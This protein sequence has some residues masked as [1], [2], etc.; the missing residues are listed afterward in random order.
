M[1]SGISKILSRALGVTLCAVCALTCQ[2]RK[3]PVQAAPEGFP[4]PTGPVR[5][6]GV[7]VPGIPWQPKVGPAQPLRVVFKSPVQRA[8]GTVAIVV[9]F[10]QPMVRLGR[11]VSKSE[12][13]SRYPLVIQPPVQAVY[14]WVAGDTLKVALTEPLL[15]AHRYRVT[16]PG[17][18]KS[19]AGSRLGKP[20]S[21]Q[22]ETPR[23]RLT[24]VERVL[25]TKVHHDRLHPSD[26]LLMTFNTQ[27]TLAEVQRS[28]ALTVNG[29]P[30][31][32]TLSR[33]KKHPKNQYLAVLAPVR[34]PPLSAA[35]SI[36]QRRG[37]RTIEGPLVADEES[38]HDF[39]V[40]GPLKPERVTCDRQA[41][42][43][44][45]KC[46]PMANGY[47][48]GLVLKL[49]EHVTQE[50]LLRHLQ[51][52][53][54]PRDLKKRLQPHYE[55][56]WIKGKQR[57]SCARGWQLQ[58]D[59][60]PR[61]AYR[62]RLTAGLRD[63][64]GQ[65]LAKTEAFRFSTRDFPPGVF[66]PSATTGFRELW[67][68]Y[69]F[70]A[71]NVK[72]VEAD[73]YTFRDA[74]L[75]RFLTCQRSS[76]DWPKHCLAKRT[77]RRV[78]VKMRGP[79]NKVLAGT[80]RLPAGL[81][82]VRFGSPQVVDYKGK[83]IL[84]HRTMTKT[85]LGLQTRLTAYGLT[86]WVTS[87]KTAKPVAGT[88]VSIFNLAGQRLWQG[89]TDPRGVAELP[90]SALGAKDGRRPPSLV[91]QA[92]T[93]ADLAYA[94]MD[95]QRSSGCDWTGYHYRYRYRSDSLDES[96]IAQCSSLRGDKP[97]LAGHVSTERGIYRPGHTVHLHGAVRRYAAWRGTPATGLTV[98]LRV[99]NSSKVEVG[100]RKVKLRDH[101]VFLARIALPS[102]GRLGYY[103]AELWAEGEKLASRSFKVAEYRPPRFVT[104]VRVRPKPVFSDG[105]L[106]VAV[107]GRYLFGGAMGGAAYNLNITRSVYSFTVPDRYEY[108]VGAYGHLV[109]LPGKTWHRSSSAL[110]NQGH[111]QTRLD[112]RAAGG[113]PLPWPCSHR[114]EAEVRSAA[115]RT[116]AG[117][118]WVRQHPGER[119]AA[120]RTLDSKGDAV[121]RH[122]LVVTPKGKARGGSTVTV[123]IYATKQGRYSWQIV[124]EWTRVLL[125]RKLK[126]PERGS[127][128]AVDWPKKYPR[129]NAVLW[130]SVTDAKGREARTAEIVY[131]PT[132]HSKAQE[133]ARR[134]Q[135]KIERE[136]TVK[137]DKDPEKERYLPGETAVITITRQGIKGDVVLFVERERIFRTIPLIFDA[138][139]KAQV[140]LKVLERYARSITLRAVTVRAGKELRGEKGALLSAGARLLVS[141]KPYELNVKLETDRKVYR[142]GK[143]VSVT[144]AVTDGLKRPRQSRVVLMAVDE[145][146]LNL[147]GYWLPDPY[148]DLAYT[149]PNGV[150]ADDIRHH[151]A[152]LGIDVIHYHHAVKPGEH[153][154]G[155][156]GGFGRGGGGGGG[157]ASGLGALMGSSVGK[158]KPRRKFLTTAWH[159]TVMTDEKGRA[160]TSFTLPDNTT[161]YRIMA[162]AV[163]RKRSAGT[164]H[165]RFEVDLP[166]LSL[167]ALPRL[168]RAGDR[169]AAGIVIYNQQTTGTA[170]VT[171]RVTGAVRLT[172]PATKHVKLVKGLGANVRFDLEALKQGTAKFTFTVRVGAQVD[173]I[174]QTLEVWRPTLMEASSV[175]GQTKGAVQ[176]GI[177]KMAG[178]RSDVG[179]L[180]VSLASTALTG[181]EDGM[182]QLIDYPYGCLEQ[183]ASRL[184]AMIAATALGDRF[185]IKLP[186]SPRLWIST[187]I[188]QVL[189]MQR[190]DGGFGYWPSSRHSWPWATAYALIVLHRAKLAKG[191]TGVTVP[192]DAVTNAKRY[193]WRY[194]RN[195]N[196]PRITGIT[197]SYFSFIVYALQF[198]GRDTT[199][200]AVK[201]AKHRL[202]QPLF[203]RSLLLATLAASPRRGGRTK[204]SNQ[205]DKLIDELADELGNSLR[206][207]GTTAH[208]EENLGWG[209]QVMMHSNDRTTAMV[210][211]ALINARPRHVM[212][213]RLVRWFLQGRKQARFRNTQE[214]AWAV[215]AL[216]DYARILEKVVPD[217]EAGV[218]IGRTRVLKAV[219]KGRSVKPQ[220]R[221]L[222]MRDIM[223]VAGRAARSLLIAKR[224]KGTL[225]YV[226][227]L[228]YARLQLP[229]KPRDRGFEVRKAVQ[230]LSNAGLPL[231]QQRPP[232]LGDTVLVTLSIKTTEARRYLVVDDPMPAGMEAID[233]SLATATRSV[234]ASLWQFRSTWYDHRELRDDRVLFFRDLVQPSTLTFRYL[235]RV[236]TP[237]RYVSP[238]TKA[239][240]MYNPEIF[241][242][243]ATRTVTYKKR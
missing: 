108:R 5:M 183:K 27:V 107:T 114:I 182:E 180:E 140:R 25:H 33:V 241:G 142:P 11:A 70:K 63:V 144:L 37:L 6:I 169:A 243:N 207:D 203:A 240:E 87:L 7:A 205:V 166:L 19:V 60:L 199:R 173:T 124:P 42:V 231:A 41:A 93:R 106:D 49:S 118:D 129:K 164:G 232:R 152:S 90:L 212:I 112:L 178:L 228:R 175:S 242:H 150:K 217:F 119:Y 121:R 135:K 125:T 74:D 193:L 97:V 172:G 236:T 32:F 222:K 154:F 227:R 209:Y 206:I 188:Q 73:L 162:F 215:M 84:W 213:L 47:R 83:Q 133:K 165:T 237:G 160:T 201:L 10:N 187:G 168:L 28:V 120:I 36:R 189:A 195:N 91:V 155:G 53:P 55:T 229:Q 134:L 234:G 174:E 226:A 110:D 145:A 68:P 138:Q 64:N 22:F 20:V 151:L 230:V 9:T 141:D 116:A 95:T 177:E 102:V 56:C 24:G 61:R 163:D 14:R 40:F 78:T 46:W 16:V 85:E 128:L 67:H 131:R 21:W 146:V 66:P 13:P 104:R 115:H 89:K 225:Y 12:D 132:R 143:K 130:L 208:A 157:G 51:I 136:L 200:Y 100:R 44:S 202:R 235:A 105:A 48:T 35:V 181:V 159:A 72:Q 184:L 139:G 30:G 57:V 216:W 170:E 123:K 75:V 167:P 223:A 69:R 153:G 59:L 79:R 31:R 62:V 186:K 211:L 171:A 233:S 86:V 99:I 149:P 81:V 15:N 161:A 82:A 113:Y 38:K 92:H 8:E 101:G 98:E 34:K 224:G 109:D 214:A 80:I 238:P 43:P 45:L 191:A 96:V 220:L 26:R 137:T 221:K 103:S 176:H 17:S 198:H 179:G 185:N 192:E 194:L 2:P 23:P 156:W 54:Q 88:T 204:L 122:V 148:R 196:R 76:S 52:T 3:W 50:A 218:W 71:V 147:T 197:F 117:Y 94:M 18:A 39:Q 190:S 126:V 4:A 65:A 158:Q 29:E 127:T 239:E 111:R 219:F 58:G 77:S 210:L 1:T